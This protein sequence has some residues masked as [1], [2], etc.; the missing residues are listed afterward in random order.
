MQIAFY[1]DISEAQNKYP[2]E[3]NPAIQIKKELNKIKYAKY[4]KNIKKFLKSSKP[5]KY[6]IELDAKTINKN[7]FTDLKK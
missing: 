6:R 3:E 5:Y 1:S 4:I 7:I 2:F